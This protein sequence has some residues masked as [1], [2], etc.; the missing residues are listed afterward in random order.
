M[1]IDVFNKT[2]YEH[3]FYVNNKILFMDI[4]FLH[5]TK[6]CSFNFFQLFKNV[7]TILSWGCTKTGDGLDLVNEL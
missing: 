7:K 2:V 4:H 5:I 3:R 1:T 6:Y